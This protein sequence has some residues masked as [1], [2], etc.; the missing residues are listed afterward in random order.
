[1]HDIKEI[2]GLPPYKYAY[3]NMTWKAE[4]YTFC[5]KTVN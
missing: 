5:L 1:M 3:W 4:I 2:K